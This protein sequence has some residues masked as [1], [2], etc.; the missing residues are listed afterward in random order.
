MGVKTDTYATIFGTDTLQAP[1]EINREHI[2]HSQG[3]N[4]RVS[5]NGE[6]DFEFT[7]RSFLIR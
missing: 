3:A 2:L 6:E 1:Q 5:D 4:D 7:N